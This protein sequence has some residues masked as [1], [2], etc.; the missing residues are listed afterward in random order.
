MRC[1]EDYVPLI[2]IAILLGLILIVES[3]GFPSPILSWISQITVMVAI[4]ASI[5]MVCFAENKWRLL[6]FPVI[7]LMVFLVYH[8]PIGLLLLLLVPTVIHVYVFTGAFILYGA[9][10]NK[11]W[12]GILSFFILL[13]CGASF[14]IF[15]P[16][17]PIEAS[18]MWIGD[19]TNYF[20]YMSSQLVS[21]FGL[22]HTSHNT[23]LSM[24]FIAF[25][26]AYHYMNW[27]SKTEVIRWHKITAKRGV[28]LTV[29]YGLAISLYLYNYKWGFF[30]LA[31]L[32]LA[33]VILEF[34]L[35]VV[36]FKSLGTSLVQFARNKILSS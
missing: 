36:V 3:V 30:V 33:H 10:K 34:P 21:V 31:G 17:S 23:L 28:V 25:A 22:A 6:F 27:F 7:A 16:H 18:A 29:L 1:R 2:V 13:C 24:K 35:D 12:P 19:Y 11:S 20:S 32:S 26:F 5:I 8:Y 9:I 15:H 14:F 4:I